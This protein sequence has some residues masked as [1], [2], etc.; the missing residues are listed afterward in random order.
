[1]KAVLS[2]FDGVLAAEKAIGLDVTSPE[3]RQEE[4]ED[5]FSIHVCICVCVCIYIY[6]YRH[7]GLYLY[8]YTYPYHI[9]SYNIIS[10]FTTPQCVYIYI[11]IY[12]HINI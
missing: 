4:L 1:M 9:I 10:C 11:Y 2:A 5:V 8:V 6:I 7:L 12:T 3:S